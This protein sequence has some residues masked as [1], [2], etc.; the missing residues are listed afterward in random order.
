MASFS[1]LLLQSLFDKVP[2][3]K[4][5]GDDKNNQNCYQ[6]C[7]K[8]KTPPCKSLPSYPPQEFPPYYD[9]IDPNSVIKYREWP[10]CIVETFEVEKNADTK[11]ML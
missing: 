9:T 1:K 10:K 7:L 11:A 6:P 3:W 8:Y 2:D 5:N 4:K